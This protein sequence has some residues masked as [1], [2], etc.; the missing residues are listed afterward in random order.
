MI[1]KRNGYSRSVE[2]KADKNGM[3]Y[4][5]GAGYNPRGM[6]GFLERLAEKKKRGFLKK[7]RNYKPSE[8]D[9]E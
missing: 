7:S 3:R 1:C 2:K 8:E 9:Y 5:K 4:A 6:I